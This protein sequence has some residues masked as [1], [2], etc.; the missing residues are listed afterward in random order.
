MEMSLVLFFM[1]DPTSL[2]IILPSTDED[3]LEP[4]CYNVDFL[5]H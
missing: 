4:T 5:L 2:D 1:G 3:S